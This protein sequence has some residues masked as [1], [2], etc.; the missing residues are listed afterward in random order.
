MKFHNCHH[1]IKGDE[2]LEPVW[3]SG[4]KVKVKN[5][6]K[7]KKEPFQWNFVKQF[8]KYQQYIEEVGYYDCIEGDLWRD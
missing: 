7:P 1:N 5:P 4:D 6:I 8:K 3:R 2:T